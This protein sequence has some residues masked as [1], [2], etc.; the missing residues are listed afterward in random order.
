MEI[1]REDSD[2]II[3]TADSIPAN[4]KVTQTFGAF[5]STQTIQISAKGLVRGFLERDRN[6]HQE[7]FDGF[8]R[9]APAGTNLI[10]GVRLSSSVAQFSDGMLLLL[11][12]MATAAQCEEVRSA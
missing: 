11:T 3:I 9:S 1:S 8:V 4:L 5:Q 10:Y 7:A 6:E 12:Y 2:V